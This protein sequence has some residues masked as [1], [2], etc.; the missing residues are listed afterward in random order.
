M[1]RANPASAGRRGES[2]VEWAGLCFGFCLGVCGCCVGLLVVVSSHYI[3]IRFN[4][5]E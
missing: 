5:V 3:K 2:A 4:V 1:R